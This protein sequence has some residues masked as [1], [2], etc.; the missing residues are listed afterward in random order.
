MGRLGENRRVLIHF[1][2]LAGT[3]LTSR[4]G[5]EN[6]CSDLVFS[7]NRQEEGNSGSRAQGMRAALGTGTGFQPLLFTTV[8]RS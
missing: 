5:K 6:C 1:L 8:P 3:T 2:K 4:Q 7:G